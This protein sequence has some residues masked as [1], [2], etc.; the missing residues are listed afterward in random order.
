VLIFLLKNKENKVKGLMNPFFM[1]YR[2]VRSPSERAKEEE[3]SGEAVPEERGIME[4]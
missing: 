4:I 2:E 1:K 3:R